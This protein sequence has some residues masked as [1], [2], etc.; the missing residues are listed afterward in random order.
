MKKSKNKNTSYY[1]NVISTNNH[2][3]IIHDA[4]KICWDQPPETE[5]EKQLQYIEK[6][7]KTGHESVLEHSNIIMY[8][9]INKNTSQY[10][11]LVEILPLFKYLNISEV[12]R[13]N[14]I[15]ILLGGSIRAYK[16]MFRE[17]KDLK[18]II[19]RS[20]EENLYV[21][22][23]KEY[24]SDFIESGIMQE[25]LFNNTFDWIPCNPITPIDDKIHIT[26]MDNYDTI[27]NELKDI[28]SIDDILNV[29]SIT[30][31]FKNM[32]RTATHQ[33]VRH[34]NAITQESQRYVD[35]SEAS[36]TSPDTLKDQYK[37]KLYDITIGGE[38]YNL[39]LSSL[40]NMLMRIYPQLR[41]QEVEKE[42][43]RA[44]LPSNVQCTKLY[45]TF[46]FKSLIKFLEL[47]TDL[48]TQIEIRQYTNI[49]YDQFIKKIESWDIGDIYKYL[50]PKYVLTECNYS[51]DDIDEILEEIILEDIEPDKPK[52][53]TDH[54]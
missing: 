10:D 18:N 12:I 1:Y 50:L 52:V 5:R 39:S 20:I 31:L 16:N 2:A 14:E 29:C 8:F 19:I 40:G 9:I 24:Y 23:D 48:S 17:C 37:D 44:F 22:S 6:R 32:S 13:D 15:H 36:F 41:K 30:I 34:R 3:Q 54:E 21:S 38:T 45:M 27:Y 43:A 46:T 42:D 28:F 7:V 11:S 25:K 4:C 35:Y 33:L 26:N 49:I 53:N 47:R 51:Y